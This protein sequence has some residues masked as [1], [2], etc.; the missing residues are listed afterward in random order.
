M[1]TSFS[2]AEL[3]R[4]ITA[5]PGVRGFEPGLG[6]TLKVL[7]SHMQ[8]AGSQRARLGVIVESDSGSATVEVS[9]D[10]S[11]P[12]RDIVRDVQETVICALSQRCEG[13]SSERK[14]PEHK[15]PER[16]DSE[17]SGSEVSRKPRVTVR[18]QSIL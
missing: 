10:G 9:V 1:M 2:V 6:S 3:T 15:E 17:P 13:A 12:V 4:L 5:V 14:V 18:V 7:G 11:R 8:P 16:K